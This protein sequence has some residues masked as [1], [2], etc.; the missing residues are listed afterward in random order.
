MKDEY[1]I[2]IN[3]FSTGLLSEVNSIFDKFDHERLPAETSRLSALDADLDV[4]FKQTTLFAI[5]KQSG[6]VSR[7][8]IRAYETFNME[9]KK[10]EKRSADQH[11][12]Y[13]AS[14]L[15]VL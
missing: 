9:K 5:E 4:F 6:E 14:S 8:L 11:L 12:A 3:E 7:Q 15:T 13:D 1:Q 2:H 10:E